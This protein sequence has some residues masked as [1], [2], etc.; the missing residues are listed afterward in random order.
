MLR[1]WFRGRGLQEEKANR[2]AYN[3]TCCDGAKPTET[4]KTSDKK[5]R[6]Q[7]NNLYNTASIYKKI[8]ETNVDHERMKGRKE[9]Y[10][11]PD[12]AV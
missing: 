4:T 9:E 5:T 1:A 2:D 7:K 8:W 11:I 12:R 3:S 6:K 10:N